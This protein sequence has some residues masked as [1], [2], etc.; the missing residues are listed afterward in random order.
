MNFLCHFSKSHKNKRDLND[1]CMNM[2]A[3][4]MKWVLLNLG[5]CQPLKTTHQN[6]CHVTRVPS[7]RST[8][9][10]WTIEAIVARCRN[11]R[12]GLSQGKEQQRLKLQN[13]SAILCMTECSE[14]TLYDVPLHRATAW[15]VGGNEDP[16]EWIQDANTSLCI[17]MCLIYNEVMKYAQCLLTSE[18]I[19][20]TA[21]TVLPPLL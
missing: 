20:Q 7:S 15:Q 1:L 2:E 14:C 13:A 12:R 6:W 21:L 9:L 18:C 8:D 10:S 5:L 16:Y 17:F 4:S 19:H 11:L 3:F